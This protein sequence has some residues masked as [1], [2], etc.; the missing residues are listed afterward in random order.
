M[1]PLGRAQR[2]PEAGLVVGRE[3][4]RRTRGS[5]FLTI[6]NPLRSP[7]AQFRLALV[8]DPIRREVG[9]LD[10]E[11]APME[12]VAVDVKVLNN[13]DVHLAAHGLLAPGVLGFGFW[14]LGFGFRISDF[15]PVLHAAAGRVM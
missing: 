3:A 2:R 7:W 5:L 4:R 12:R 15:G 11:R 9:Y 1:A 14:V 10:T 8:W 13:Q 6:D